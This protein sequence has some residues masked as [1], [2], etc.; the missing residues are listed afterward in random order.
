MS[1]Y[2][3]LGSVGAFIL[4]HAISMVLNVVYSP[5]L[6]YEEV[7]QC[8]GIPAL[9]CGSPFEDIAKEI[10]NVGSFGILNLIGLFAKAGPLLFDLL[11]LNYAF[12]WGGGDIAEGIGLVI[13]L[14]GWAAV[15][16]AFMALAVQLLGR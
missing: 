1:T 14:F 13:R 4:I 9:A 6:P 16:S 10:S 15:L 11:M 7:L 12:Y 2:L 8:A 3:A 5:L